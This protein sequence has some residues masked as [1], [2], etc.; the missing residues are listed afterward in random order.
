MRLPLWHLCQRRAPQRRGRLLLPRECPSRRTT[1]M[2]RRITDGRTAASISGSG[3]AGSP[4]GA[5]SLSGP[6]V[7]CVPHQACISC[8]SVV[9]SA[10]G[11]V[12]GGHGNF[13]LASESPKAR[14]R[15]IACAHAPVAGLHLHTCIRLSILSTVQHEHGDALSH[16]SWWGLVSMRDGVSL[17]A[18]GMKESGGM[19]RNMGWE[20][21]WRWM[22]RHTMASGPRVPCMERGCG[23]SH[24]CLIRSTHCVSC[25]DL[26]A[27]GGRGT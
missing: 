25:G 10:A 6:Q 21:W 19:A 4:T 16:L 3:M 27:L 2:G 9:S 13:S 17:Q 22:A 11:H 24:A 12:S 23:L 7:T 18:Q 8:G 15:S 14:P 20:R 26:A 1:T 5:A